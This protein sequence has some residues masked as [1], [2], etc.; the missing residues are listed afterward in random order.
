MA[1]QQPT[2]RPPW[3]DMAQ[4][5]NNLVFNPQSMGFNPGSLEAVQPTQRGMNV[6]NQMQP[7]AAPMSQTPMQMPLANPQQLLGELVANRNLARDQQVKGI[8]DT[9]DLLKSHLENSKKGQIDLSPVLALADAWTGSRLAQSYQKPTDSKSYLET[10]AALQN[11]LQK[12][13][14]ALTDDEQNFLLSQLK[15]QQQLEDASLGRDVARERMRTQEK[16]AAMASDT[17]NGGVN[18]TPGQKTLDS[19]FA[20][21]L[22]EWTSGGEVAVDKNL[23][24]LKEAKDKLKSLG[25]TSVSGRVVGRLPDFLRSEESL[26]IQQDVQ[27]AAQGALRATLGSQFTEKEGQRIMQNSYDPRLS[28]EENIRKIDAAIRELETQKQ[29]K[30]RKAQEFEQRGTLKDYRSK[31]QSMERAPS[32]PASQPSPSGMTREEKIKLLQERAARGGN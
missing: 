26:A 21:D 24:R 7:S 4:D 1:A 20:K 11:L 31:G 8:K 32:A 25:D 2:Q 16:I 17:K 18:L 14:G 9:E 15:L 12:S 13:R 3:L 5:P 19:T 10:T 27:G 22:D 29:N 23:Q 6:A 28:P 30:N